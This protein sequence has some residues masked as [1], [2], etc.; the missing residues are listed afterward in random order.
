MEP[1]SRRGRAYLLQS[2]TTTTSQ[3]MKLMFNYK[4]EYT[5][6]G[7]PAGA[8]LNIPLLVF[9]SIMCLTCLSCWPMSPLANQSPSMPPPSPPPLL[10]SSEYEDDEEGAAATAPVGS[11]ELAPAVVLAG[12]QEEPARSSNATR[13]QTAEQ[14][15]DFFYLNSLFSHI[16]KQWKFAEMILIIVISAILNLV[17]II[18]NIMV[19]I[20]FKM[21]RS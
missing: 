9:A 11:G 7:G 2:T 10:S 21:D 5:I 12:L 16:D 13:G 8:R 4:S 14:S 20:S 19:L 3:E 18:G 6:G 15:S 1:T 17:T